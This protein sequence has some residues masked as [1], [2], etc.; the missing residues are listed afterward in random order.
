MITFNEKEQGILDLAVQ[1]VNIFL[2][3]PAGTGKTTLIIE[4]RKRFKEKNIRYAITATTGAAA[5]NLGGSTLHS[6][7]GIGLGTQKAEELYEKVARNNKYM[8][9]WKETQV[10][11]IDEVSMLGGHLLTKIDYIARRVRGQKNSPFGGMQ[12]IISGD[13]LQLPPIND[14][15]VF[16][17][18]AWKD[19]DF[20]IFDLDESKRYGEKDHFEFLQRARKAR[21]TYEDIEMLKK[22]QEEYKKMDI[23]TMEVKPTILYSKRMDVDDYNNIELSKLPGKEYVFDCVDSF[24]KKRAPVITEADKSQF[25]KLMNDAIPE[26]ITLKVGAQVMLRKN[27]QDMPL[28]NG[29]RGVILEINYEKKDITV[30]FANGIVH[31]LGYETWEVE[32]DYINLTR[33]QMPLI[34]AYAITIH[35]IQGATLDCTVASVGKEIFSPA[36]GYVALSRVRDIKNLYLTD[37]VESSIKADP[38]AL[39]FVEN[40]EPIEIEYRYVDDEKDVGIDVE[41]YETEYYV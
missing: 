7:A 1:G 24:L 15:W 20:Y 19:L 5:S 16:E 28:V 4:M 2:H 6:F 21:L 8:K 17:S 34:L 31:T 3:G 35:K 14:C 32:D 11:V 13:L 41:E 39:K 40:I 10:L 22:R 18:E 37:F 25:K 30:K 12:L 9:R 33:S 26:K 23:K 38:V 27:L 29:S 36:Q